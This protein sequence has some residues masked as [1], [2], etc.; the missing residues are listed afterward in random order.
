MCC[1]NPTLMLGKIK[2]K[3][4]QDLSFKYDDNP[5]QQPNFLNPKL[6]CISALSHRRFTPTRVEWIPL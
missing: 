6:L 1:L 3:Y 2:F 4:G 5:N